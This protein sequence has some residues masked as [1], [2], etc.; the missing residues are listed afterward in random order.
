MSTMGGSVVVSSENLFSSP[1]QNPNF[2]FMPTI[3][4]QP[5]HASMVTK[6]KNP[7]YLLFLLLFFFA[8]LCKKMM[9]IYILKL[10]KEE[11]GLLRGK[12]EIM[13]SGSGSEQLVD[14][15]KS[16]NEE[17]ESS[18]QQ[19][20]TKK[21]RYHRHTARQIQEMEAYIYHLSLFIFFSWI[22]LCL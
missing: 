3:P 9:H 4:F 14:Q 10:Q 5:F 21:K 12:E 1:I 20:A 8:C 17:Q 11:D 7:F 22:S 19:Q 13:E 2:N 6:N 18:E 16:G 15:D